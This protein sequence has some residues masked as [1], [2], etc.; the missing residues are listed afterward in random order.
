VTAGGGSPGDRDERIE[1][2]ASAREGE[3]NTHPAGRLTFVEQRRAPAG[4]QP[5]SAYDGAVSVT[6]VLAAAVAGLATFLSPCA[7]PIVPVVLAS[8]TTG[9]RRRP[10][11]VALGLALAFVAFTLAASRVLAALGLPQDLLHTI[12]VALLAFVGLMLV[13]PMLAEWAG[14]LFQ[15]LAN[16]AGGRVPGGDG[17]A[18]GL[19]LGAALA[20]VWTPCAGPILAAVTVLAAERHVS[21]NL[22]LITVA[23]AAGA[24]LP[25]FVLVLLG[26][27]AVAGFARVRRHGLALRRASGVVLLLSAWLFT[28]NLPTRLAAATPG[29]LSWIQSP[30][31]SSAVKTDLR[32]LDKSKTHSRAALAAGNSP[33]RLK[34]FGPAPD[35]AGISAWI[36]TP[37]SRPLSL[38]KLRGKVVLVDFWTYSCVNCIRTLPYLKAWYSRYHAAG[39]VIVGV[40]TPE[41]AFEHVV[42]NVRRAVGEHD[43]R[44]PVAV[45]NG[46]KTWN[47]WANQYWPADYLIDRTGH[48]RDAHFG[49]GA[50]RQTEDKIRT[51][52]GERTSMPHA[53]PHGAIGVSG[54][55][56]TPETYL[57]SFRAQYSQAVHAGK[58]WNYTA[59]RNAYVNDVQLQ[60]Q[61]RVE[62]QRIVAGQ[63][64]HLLLRYVA[65]R[66]YVVAAPPSDGGG[67]IAVSVD[68]KHLPRIPVP[69]DDLYQLAHLAKAGPHKLD[70]AVR[71]GTSLYSFTFG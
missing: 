4:D 43:I 5:R 40:H 28:T 57:G 31:R 6:L 64:A 36:N 23:Y 66:I 61:W 44:Y 71:P 33:D 17:F 29:Y 18:S 1:V 30:E 50:Y 35:F 27:R 70:L 21:G 42:G 19:V 38:A 46:Y 47:A 13:A 20:V 34:D 26:Q 25:L 62:S 52:L 63:G 2:A 51:L 11:G 39:L 53:E 56:Q 32:S 68:G 41:F 3:E 12:A 48:V 49:E 54:A 65:P 60:G 15:P 55:V 67:S 9:G 10:F 7:L 16:R 24:T 59:E 58:S 45:D 8:G 69:H 14:R 37:G 22:V